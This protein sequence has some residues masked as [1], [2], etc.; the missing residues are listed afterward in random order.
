MPTYTYKC[1]SCNKKQEIFQKLTDVALTTC[2][3]CETETFERII[4]PIPAHFKCGG[5][6]ATDYAA[7]NHVVNN[8]KK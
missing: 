5:F 7:V 1:F 2:P 4:T 8:I 3:K 6:Y